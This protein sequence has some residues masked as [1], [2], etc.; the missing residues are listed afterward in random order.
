MWTHWLFIRGRNSLLL[1]TSCLSPLTQAG[2]AG[3]PVDPALPSRARESW[4]SPH[5]LWKSIWSW[6]SALTLA[7]SVGQASVSSPMEYSDSLLNLWTFLP[8]S[9]PSYT[10]LA[11]KMRF[12][13]FF[14]SLLSSKNS[15]CL[16]HQVWALSWFWETLVLHLHLANWLSHLSQYSRPLFLS[17]LCITLGWKS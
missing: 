5:F 14:I 16:L 1:P 9:L 15:Q 17:V 3:V 7:T 13:V 10:I 12:P 2:S 6:P 4:A 8:L 11:D